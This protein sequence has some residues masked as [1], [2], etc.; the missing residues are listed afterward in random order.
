MENIVIAL[1]LKHPAHWRCGRCA[2]WQGTT[3]L[4]PHPPGRKCDNCGGDFLRYDP[5]QAAAEPCIR[6]AYMNGLMELLCHQAS[7]YARTVLDRVEQ[8]SADEMAAVAADILPRYIEQVEN[9]V[10]AVQPPEHRYLHAP[11]GG[12][13]VVVPE[14]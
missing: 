10:L 5:Q 1:D 8:L 6:A 12:E 11:D 7:P 3:L 2:N 13:C 4:Y 9:R 14:P